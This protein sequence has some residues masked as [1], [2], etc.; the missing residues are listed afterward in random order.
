MKNELEDKFEGS[1]LQTEIRNLT[2]D[3]LKKFHQMILI[4]Y[5]GNPDSQFWQDA[6]EFIDNKKN[7]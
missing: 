5:L 2:G 4:A 6:V 1:I 3:R 7:K